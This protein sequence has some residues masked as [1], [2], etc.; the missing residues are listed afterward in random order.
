MELDVRIRSHTGAHNRIRSRA[1]L[2]VAILEA[3]RREGASMATTHDSQAVKAFKAKH[4]RA[5]RRSVNPRDADE[6]WIQHWKATQLSKLYRD[7]NYALVHARRTVSRDKRTA[8]L[9]LKVA[10]N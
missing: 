5:P 10:H 3:R 4:G 1:M 6:A 7:P 9:R 8:K 2:G